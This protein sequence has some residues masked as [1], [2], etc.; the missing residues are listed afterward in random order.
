MIIYI[1]MPMFPVGN[2]YCVHIDNAHGVNHCV[3][4]TLCAVNWY[5]FMP[6][7]PVGNAHCVPIK[8]AHGVKYAVVVAICRL[9][10]LLSNSCCSRWARTYC[11]LAVQRSATSAVHNTL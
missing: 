10:V 4:N 2:A 1:Y 9:Y 6:L 3:S 11:D 5:Y 7:F 8:N